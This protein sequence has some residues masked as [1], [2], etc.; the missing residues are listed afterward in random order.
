MSYEQYNINQ[1]DRTYQEQR[2]ERARQAQSAQGNKTNRNPMSGIIK[3]AQ[4]ITSIRSQPA[5][6]EPVPNWKQQST[7]STI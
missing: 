5:Q 2:A 7:A 3:M 4:K 6:Q 1:A